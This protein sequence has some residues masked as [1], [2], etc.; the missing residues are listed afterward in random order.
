MVPVLQCYQA[1]LPAPHRRPLHF[2][3]HGQS[4]P[5]PHQPFEN[6]H[7][8]I[9][10]ALPNAMTLDRGPILVR[11]LVPYASSVQLRTAF[12]LLVSQP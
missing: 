4:R 1:K 7:V 9:L 3:F 2:A 10:L 6:V 5:V 12:H 11:I 8:V